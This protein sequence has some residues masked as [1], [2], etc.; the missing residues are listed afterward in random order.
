MDA[1]KREH[2]G[3]ILSECLSFDAGSR[4]FGPAKTWLTALARTSSFEK[5]PGGSVPAIQRQATRLLVPLCV[6]GGR[7]HHRRDMRIKKPAPRHAAAHMRRCEIFC[8][9]IFAPKYLLYVSGREP[10]GVELCAS[11]CTSQTPTLV[12]TANTRRD[13]LFA[14]AACRARTPARSLHQGPDQDQRLFA[15]GAFSGSPVPSGNP[16]WW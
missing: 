10:T 11:L 12:P 16:K 8:C 9:K 3:G 5:G 13:L 15:R 1:T 14:V 6:C 7:S 4:R 2:C